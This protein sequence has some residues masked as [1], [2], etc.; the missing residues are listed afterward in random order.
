MYSLFKAT[1]DTYFYYIG[2]KLIQLDDGNNSQD[3][4]TPFTAAA[5]KILLL[6]LK[7]IY[8]MSK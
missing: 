2:S 8:F 7:K 1:A 4:K 5:N 6:L 3:C